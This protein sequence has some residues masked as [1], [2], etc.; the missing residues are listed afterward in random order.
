VITW[1]PNL[2]LR[3]A[4]ERTRPAVDLVS[5]IEISDPR[6]IIDLGCG[7]G[8]ST[9]VLR[10]RWPS[11]DITGLDS[12][13]AMIATAAKSDANVRWVHGDAADWHPD[14]QYNL[15][16]SNA[17]LQWVP[18]HADVVPRLLAAVARGGALAVQ[19]PAHTRSP[20]HQHVLAVA[21]EPEWCDAV[22]QACAA[23]NTHEPQFYYDLLC[24]AAERINMW[25]TEYDHVVN[26]PED[27]LTWI[28]GTGLRPFLTALSDDEERQRFESLLIERVANSYPRRRDGRVLFPFQRL[29]FVAYR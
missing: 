23:I 19:I 20:L 29:F 27:I 28:R 9:A 5:R 16:F 10:T 3:F 24:D 21:G 1:D 7:P 11:A 4:N 26:G 14:E 2:Y 22:R 18:D 12:D 17:M 15:V 25:Q 8:N 13:P 6:R